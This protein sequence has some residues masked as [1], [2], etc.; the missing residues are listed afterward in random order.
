L[1]ERDKYEQMWQGDKYRQKSPAFHRFFDEIKSYV[2][3]SGKVIE[4]GCGQGLA[5]EALSKDHEVLGID[6]A[7][8][9][10]TVDVPF[11]RACLW[12]PMNVV[13][14]VGFC[15]DVMEHIPPEYV[16]Q[17][18]EE[19]LN[20]VPKCF[21][22]ACILP[23]SN[24]QRHIGQSLHLTVEDHNWWNAEAKKHGKVTSF[25]TTHRASHFGLSRK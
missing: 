10:L 12:E 3:G 20:C 6:I 8:N 18:F 2:K 11:K 17:T 13:G 4:F 25:R 22:I 24:G 19:I 9:C 7:Q 16:S 1:V 23:D 5:L 14:D 21:F 15:V